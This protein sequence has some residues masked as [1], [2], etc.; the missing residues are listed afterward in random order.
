MQ[1]AMDLTQ[2]CR[3]GRETARE[4]DGGGDR[5]REIERGGGAL[6]TPCQ[7]CKPEMSTGHTRLYKPELPKYHADVAFRAAPDRP[8]ARTSFGRPM[9]PAAIFTSSYTFRNAA[10]VFEVC[11]Y[12]QWTP[13]RKTK[14]CEIMSNNHHNTF[15]GADHCSRW[16]PMERWRRF[17]VVGGWLTWPR[18]DRGPNPTALIPAP[19]G[20]A[21][22]CYG[23]VHYGWI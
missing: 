13:M 16:I 11:S 23:V 9:P 3:G 18:S 2:G 21:M 20:S 12:G 17:R 6:P 4:R 14:H 7:H 5:E 22:V 19:K 1:W 15:S 10:I 8:A